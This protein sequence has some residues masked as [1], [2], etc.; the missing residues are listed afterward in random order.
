MTLRNAKKLK[1]NDEV[2]V[3]DGPDIY[4]V[5]SDKYLSICMQQVCLNFY[6]IRKRDGK[7]ME[8]VFSHWELQ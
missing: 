4:R 5:A 7:L 8:R 6:L 2:K 1:T 3:K